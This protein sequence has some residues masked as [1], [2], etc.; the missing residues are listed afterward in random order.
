MVNTAKLE[1]VSD[2]NAPAVVFPGDNQVQRL[3][4]GYSAARMAVFRHVPL[5]YELSYDQAVLA[6]EIIGENVNRNGDAI[7]SQLEQGK[8]L[9][10]A[11]ALTMSS[12]DARQYMLAQYALA[13]EGLGA[14]T[15]G[16]ADDAVAKG[17]L[18]RADYD[19]VCAKKLE[20]FGHIV[21]LEQKN[22]LAHLLSAEK[23]ATQTAAAQAAQGRP[24]LAPNKLWIR[25]GSNGVEGSLA[26]L[27]IG[28]GVVVIIAIAAVVTV[29]VVVKLWLDYKANLN[30]AQ[31][32][33]DQCISAQK[34]GYNTVVEACSKNMS[35]LETKGLAEQLFGKDA[36]SQVTKYI[37]IGVG[38]YLLVAFGPRIVDMLGA[39]GDRIQERRA[40][41]ALT[42]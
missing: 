10:D 3:L 22:G 15:S 28:A 38:L 20:V 33:H 11:I 13:C 39:T 36:T 41:K 42:A 25:T 16:Y 9:Y 35:G 8:D 40:R 31:L 4:S 5:E 12:E 17:T 34:Y 6:S 27:G 29:C 23:V 2:R 14:W 7:L 18:S 32:A 21:A 30:Q 1:A 19:A 24:S 26:G 37:A